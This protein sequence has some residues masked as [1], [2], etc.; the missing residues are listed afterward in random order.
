MNLNALIPDFKALGKIDWSKPQV[1]TKNVCAL[2]TLAGAVLML[3]FCFCPW[4]GLKNPEES[5]TITRLGI[6]LWYG[7]FGFIFALVTVAGTLY[8]QHALAFCASVLCLLMGL[9]GMVCWASLKQDG[10]EVDGDLL[11]DMVELGKAFG[12]KISVVRWG[13]ILY[14]ISAL[15]AA[16]GS[17]CSATG[18]E[19]KK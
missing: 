13:A 17:F 16:G 6:T 2:A 18:L 5:E 9:L 11:K 1:D 8:R 4:F 14:F 19:L 7:I 12:A 15:V 10:I 3:I